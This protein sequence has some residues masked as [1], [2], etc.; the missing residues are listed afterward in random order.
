MKVFHSNKKQNV[1]IGL[2]KL[3]PK[4]ERGRKI[5]DSTVTFLPHSIITR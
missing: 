4:K 3:F 5:T 2:K 1:I